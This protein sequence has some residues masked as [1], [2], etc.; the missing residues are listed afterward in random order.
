MT[1]SKSYATSVARL[2]EL[3]E[4]QVYLNEFFDT[5]MIALQRPSNVQLLKS[6]PYMDMMKKL[7]LIQDSRSK[8]NKRGNSLSLLTTFSPEQLE[9]LHYIRILDSGHIDSMWAAIR[10]FI[11]ETNLK[12]YIDNSKT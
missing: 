11:A 9:E 8:F 6:Q 3:S 7:S 1:E 4:R 2:S 12:I 5:M 10:E